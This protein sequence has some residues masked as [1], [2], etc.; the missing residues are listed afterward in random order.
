MRSLKRISALTRR[1]LKEIIRDPLSLIFM[2]ALPLL[3]L[4]LFYLIFHK[5]TP[6]FEM[7]YLAPG[8]VIFGQTFLALFAGILISLDRSSSFLTRLYVSPAK[9]YEFI[10]AYFFALIPLGLLQSCLFF[11]TAVIIDFSF[12]SAYIFLGILS[13]LITS[14]LFI[15]FGI[16]FGTL[17]NEKSVGGI[18]SI[19]IVGQSVLSGMWFPL[20]GLDD[21]FISFMNA[22]P[23][24]NG[25]VFMQNVSTGNFS[26]PMKGVFLP[27][28]ILFTYIIV[29]FAVSVFVFHIKKTKK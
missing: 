5:L 20:E 10:A 15:S 17:C 28:I 13:S 16:L 14:L 27:L 6:Q 24:R 12:F 18:T 9:S 25:T 1:N 22:L 19:I 3:M 23:F 4:I 8:I 29:V 11:L 26:E 21:G 2:L 7:K